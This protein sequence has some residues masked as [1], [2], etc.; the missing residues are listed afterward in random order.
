VVKFNYEVFRKST[1]EDKKNYLF[2]LLK[3]SNLLRNKILNT[4][5]FFLFTKTKRKDAKW[6]KWFI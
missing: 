6:W 3:E 1:K 5:I 4:I 2:T